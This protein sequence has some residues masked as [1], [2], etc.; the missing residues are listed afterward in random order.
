MKLRIEIEPGAEKELILRAPAIDDDVRR[1]QAAIAS[2]SENPEEIALKFAGGEIFVPYRELYFFEV[3]G[4]KTYAHTATECFVCPSHLFELERML[5]P[6]FCRA[7]KSIL[8]NVSRIKSISRS[9]TGVGEAA[10]FGTEKKIFIS[11]MYYKQ[12]R[13]VIE[14][15]RLKK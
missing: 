4:E 5:P 15:V 9:A 14:E 12:V 7:S 10:F 3:S 1:V 6:A 13:D 11:R 8:V 2:L